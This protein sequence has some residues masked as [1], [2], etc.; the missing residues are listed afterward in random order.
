MT[1]CPPKTVCENSRYRPVLS[2]KR[3]ILPHEQSHAN[4]LH[5]A[6]CRRGAALNPVA[7]SLYVAKQRLEFFVRFAGFVFQLSYRSGLPN[8]IA[9]KKANTNHG[10]ASLRPYVWACAGVFYVYLRVFQVRCLSLNRRSLSRG[11]LH[12][13]ARLRA[14]EFPHTH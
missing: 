1:P 12:Y 5:G 3:L 10:F 11:S 13:A 8:Y 4:V 2:I 6:G 14:F 9:N 7:L